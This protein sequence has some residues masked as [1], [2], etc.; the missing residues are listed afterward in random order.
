[1]LSNCLT[2]V[3]FMSFALDYVLINCFVFSDYS[4]YVCFLVLYVLLFILCAP[5]FVLFRALFLSM[6]SFLSS[7]CVQIYRPLPPGGYPNARNKY[8]IKYHII[9]FVLRTF[10]ISFASCKYYVS[11][12]TSRQCITHI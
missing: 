4:F 3:C 10:M 1:L 9:Q 5:C 2:A 12:G 6:Y 11:Y 8:H 7:I